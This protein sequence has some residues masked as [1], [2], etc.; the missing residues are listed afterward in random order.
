[1]VD[2][3]N[4]VKLS[5]TIKVKRAA[6]SKLEDI[7]LRHNGIIYGGYVRDTMIS[8][9]FSSQFSIKHPSNEGGI[10]HPRY[11]DK[12]F[13]PE[14]AKRLIVPSDIDL[15]FRSSEE[16]DNFIAS[17]EDVP[18]F[19]E[20]Y[21]SNITTN[22]YYSSN[23]QSMKHL[24]IQ[25]VIGEVPFL[26][27]GL[28]VYIQ[29]DIIIPN[30]SIYPPFN[31]LDI[32]C[33]GFIKSKEGICFSRN[34]GTIIDFYSEVRHMQVVAGIA[35]DM[36]QSKTYCCFSK[37]SPEDTT[38]YNFNIIAM[39]RIMKMHNKD[40]TFLNLPF[41]TDLFKLVDKA[42]QEDCSI[43]M[44]EL[45]Q[46]EQVS[47]TVRRENNKELCG[48]KMHY[49]CF[50]NYLSHQRL[51]ARQNPAENDEVFIFR[52]PYR[53]PI[54]LRHCIFDIKNIYINNV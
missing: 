2:H 3:A 28:T 9:E 46:G 39:R 22:K 36:L 6:F 53:N 1:M 47:Y 34:T 32:L 52:C 43:C 24:L 18:E 15:S 40:W 42:Q 13:S 20:V 37:S 16:A 38:S 31:N 51:A 21:V 54:D 48:C 12:N 45:K 29:A 30:S 23:I 5:T 44:G 8:E 19:R 10:N 50:M 26:S 17:V 35:N 11:W 49:T 7:A 14:T 25:L 41:R 33:N 27:N 4:K